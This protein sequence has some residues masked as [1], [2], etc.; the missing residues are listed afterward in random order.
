MGTLIKRILKSR[1]LKNAIILGRDRQLE[2]E[3][4]SVIK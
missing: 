2:G 1:I 3:S 4:T